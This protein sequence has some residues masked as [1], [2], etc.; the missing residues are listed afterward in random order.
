MTGWIV[1]GLLGALAL[2]FVCGFFF[3]AVVLAWLA[4]RDPTWAASFAAKLTRR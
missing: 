3:F 1:L 4:E 2:G